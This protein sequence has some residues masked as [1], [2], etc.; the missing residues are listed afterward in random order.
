MPYNI[1][2]GLIIYI[3]IWWHMSIFKKENF[4]IECKKS[5]SPGNFLKKYS[6][7]LKPFKNSIFIPDVETTSR[8]P[9]EKEN[10]KGSTAIGGRWAS[11]LREWVELG[12]GTY[13]TTPRCRVL[14]VGVA[15]KVFSWDLD[16]L[17]NEEKVEL[18]HDTLHE[19]I[20]LGHNISFDLMWM[21]HI[22]DKSLPG[23]WLKIKPKY[24]LDSMLLARF[25]FNV[26]IEG[27]TKS[28]NVIP[29]SKRKKLFQENIPRVSME[30]MCYALK[31]APP[32]KTFQKPANWM[33]SMLDEERFDYVTGDVQNPE[34]FLLKIAN[35]F[36]RS[37]KPTQGPIFTEPL[38]AARYLD[39]VWPFLKEYSGSLFVS[40]RAGR[41]GVPFDI[42][43]STN[44]LKKLK[45]EFLLSVD[46]L[47][48]NESFKSI[49]NTLT[50]YTKGEPSKLKDILIDY[51]K[52]LGKTPEL[53]EKT[54]KPSLS[55]DS[56][57]IIGVS[58]D[59]ICKAYMARR[60]LQKNIDTVTQ[61][62][63]YSKAGDGYVHP[64]LAPRANS[65]RESSESPNAQNLPTPP[66][67]RA[68]VKAKNH[69]GEKHLIIATD[70]SAIE[71]RIAVALAVRAFN[72]ITEI[73]KT[74][75]VP[76]S[77]KWM[78]KDFI[79]KYECGDIVSLPERPIGDN[80]GMLA[81]KDYYSSL[82]AYL[83]EK[84]KDM[85]M[86]NGFKTLGDL[87]L[88]TAISFIKDIDLKGL[89]AIEYLS[90]LTKEE[91]AQLKEKYKKQ[92][93]QA[94]AVNF[95]NLYGAEASGLWTYGITSYGLD[96]TL[97][98]AAESRAAWFNAYPDAHLWQIWTKLTPYEKKV[99]YNTAWGIEKNGKIWHE[100][101]LSN[102]LFITTG[103]TNALN[104]QDQGTG[105]DILARCKNTLP[106]DLEDKFLLAV[107][108]ELLFNIPASKAEMYKEKIESHMIDAANYYMKPYGVPVEVE[109][110]IGDVWIH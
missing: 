99:E 34:I 5:P 109:S 22:M 38:M 11:S 79:N 74:K 64:V 110:S 96:W 63:E 43:H 35:D 73:I 19:N 21:L 31:I 12:Y 36:S 97:E 58:N 70:Y 18:I 67:Y 56:L 27:L 78:W 54:G 82:L 57:A 76:P 92:R 4:T 75:N 20:I 71:L 45:T 91:R 52:T 90:R 23:S 83:Y 69:N 98:E 17:S 51:I 89:S 62:I 7:E 37:L 93:Q 42:E 104:L 95:G 6:S 85:P 105:A 40:A 53:S 26:M 103:Y 41:R 28:K 47:T 86:L 1:A 15:G 60:H 88:P 87:H 39:K 25:R 65:L 9:A 94:K 2:I 14:T 8:H 24:I 13:D 106:V 32:D 77:I 108:D 102:R 16:F 48:K 3:T 84:A 55:D 72:K 81:W 50:D 30:A 29:I 100:T 107:H 33:L 80:A 68:M 10:V 66:E 49:E 44:L 59:T 101:T 61:W 46:E